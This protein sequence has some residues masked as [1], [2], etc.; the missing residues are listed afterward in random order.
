MRKMS[1]Q[2]GRHDDGL[3]LHAEGVIGEKVGFGDHHF[4]RLFPVADLEGWGRKKKNT[5]D[6]LEP[7]VTFY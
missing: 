3:V 2:D 5:L 6:A 4:V 7:V 1:Y